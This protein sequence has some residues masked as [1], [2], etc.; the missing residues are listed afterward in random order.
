MYSRNVNALPLFKYQDEAAELIASRERFGLHD[1]M[2][3]GKTATTIGALDKSGSV[4]NIIVCPAM[5]RENWIR[6]IRKFSQ[7]HR[8][9]CK[10]RT[11]H[12]F[13]AW[14]RGRF[15]TLVTS[16]EMATRWVEEFVKEGEFIDYLAMDEAHY[17]KNHK[18]NRSRALL[19]PEAGG[20]EC[21]STFATQG[22]HITGTP[23]A[24]DPMDVYTFLR[25]SGA[26][27]MDP[28]RFSD[29]FFYKKIGTYNVRHYPKDDMVDTL[30]QL[31]YNNS[32]RRNHEDVGME[33]PPI[34][35]TELLVEGS[36]LEIN[37]LL[38]AYP[39]LERVIIEAVETGDVGALEVE[40]IARLR[41]LLA[42][43]KAVPYAE[44][45]KHELD[46]STGKRVV[47]CWHTEALLHVVNYIN[48]KTNAYYAVCAYGET[49][50]DER[51]SAVDRFMNDPY[52]RVFVGNMTVAGHGLTLTESSEIDM[53]ESSYTPATNAQA[54]KRVHRYG[55]RNAVRARFITL[56]DSFD[57]AVNGIVAS[58]TASI[59]RVERDRAMTA[60][61]NGLTA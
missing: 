33:L 5:L 1:E 60:S 46:S 54:L 21:F 38:E 50:E 30:Q 59:A 14:Q 19:G 45:L 8:R 4:R 48:R 47:M 7:V 23:M 15:D 3:I 53:L 36:N 10:G 29:T 35:L 24:N 16:Y 34:W 11:I 51:V 57:V 12:D 39:N 41:R 26:I 43:A 31:I 20:G 37:K 25:W 13:I 52:C 18:T 22:V 6:E 40:H 56:A 17:M 2:G 55:Q 44:L 9:V 28:A 58:K 42:K 32:L 61:P 49:G 27:D